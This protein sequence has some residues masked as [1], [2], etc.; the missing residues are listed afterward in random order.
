LGILAGATLFAADLVLS[1]SLAIG[2]AYVTLRL[3]SLWMPDRRSTVAIATVATGLIVAAFFLTRG[4]ETQLVAAASDRGFAVLAIWAAVVLI[5]RWKGRA[6]R[7][8][9]KLALTAA[10]R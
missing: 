2:A 5:V 9:R 1:P 3:I 7:S 4:D 8:G 10:L 6:T